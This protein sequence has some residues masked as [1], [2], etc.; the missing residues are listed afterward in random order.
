MPKFEQYVSTPEGWS[1][2]GLSVFE[3]KHLAPTAFDLPKF[4]QYPPFAAFIQEKEYRREDRDVELMAAEIIEGA[5]DGMDVTGWRQRNMGQAGM[6]QCLWGLLL[7]SEFKVLNRYMRSPE[8]KI[9]G[10]QEYSE[11]VM[12]VRRFVCARLFPELHL[13]NEGYVMHWNDDPFR[14]FGQVRDRLMHVAKDIRNEER[15]CSW[16]AEMARWPLKSGHRN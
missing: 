3:S 16:V 1:L 9:K 13:A 12:R 6:P 5:V 15:R 4:P 2:E 11:M 8:G 10:I 7:T 14:T